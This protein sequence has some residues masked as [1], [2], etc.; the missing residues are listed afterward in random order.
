MRNPFRFGNALSAAFS[1]KQPLFLLAAFCA[2]LLFSEELPLDRKAFAPAAAKGQKIT[3]VTYAEK[4]ALHFEW[5]CDQCPWAEFWWDNRPLLPDFGQLRIRVTAK[6]G[7]AARPGM[8]SLRFIDRDGEAFQ[9]GNPLRFDEKGI[10]ETEFLIP[11]NYKIHSAWKSNTESVLNGKIDQPLRFGGFCFQYPG[12]SGK[13]EVD[14]TKVE[15]DSRNDEIGAVAGTSV[16]FPVQFDIETGHPVRVVTPETASSSVLVLRNTGDAELVP[17][18][19]FTVYDR[20]GGIVGRSWTER[21]LIGKN[22]SR[23]LLLPRMEKFGIYYVEAEITCKN[24]PVQKIVRSFAYLEPTGHAEPYCKG[25]FRFGVNTDFCHD[26]VTWHKEGEACRTI[27]MRFIRNG[28]TLSHFPET[29]KFPEYATA[30]IDTFL[31][32]GVMTEYLLFGGGQP[33]ALQQPE[34]AARDRPNTFMPNLEAWRRYCRETFS[35]LKTRV[36]AFEVWNEPDLRSFA[37]FSPEEYVQLARIARE[38]QRKIAPDAE[39]LSAGFCVAEQD[40]FQEKAMRLC[41]ELFDVHCFHG[42]GPFESY[43]TIITR[44]FLPMRERLGIAGVMPWYAHETAISSS[45][46]GE[47]LQAETYF[48]KLLFSWRHGAIG[49]TWYNLHNN[50]T[51]PNN[52]EHNYG[53]LTYD[54]YP[55]AVFVAGNTLT[56]L[57]G[58][59]TRYEADLSEIPYFTAYR[60]HREKQEFLFPAWH[61][62]RGGRAELR[63]RTDAKNA[64]NVDLQGNRTPLQIQDGVVIFPVSGE[65]STLRLTG[66]TRCDKLGDSVKSAEREMRFGETGGTAVLTVINP[67][68]NPVNLTIEQEPMEGIAMRPLAPQRFLP[69]EERR[70]ELQFH[71]DAAKPIAGHPVRLRY[72]LGAETGLVE[73]P[74]LPVWKLSPDFTGVP[75]AVLDKRSQMVELFDADPANVFR[76]R[77][78]NSDL[79]CRLELAGDENSFRLRAEVIDD[80]HRQPNRGAAIFKGDSIQLFLA[81]PGQKQVWQLGCAL[82]DQ[83]KVEPYIWEAGAPGGKTGPGNFPCR[84][85]RAGTKTVYEVTLPWNELGVSAQEAKQGFRFNFLVNESDSDVR[86]SFLRLAPGAGE[87]LEPDQFPLLRL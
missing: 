43:R 75:F 7:T 3:N 53:M 16:S 71:G 72:S 74:V 24:H 65:P 58:G 2:V 30:Y 26:P 48:K 33:W 12:Q 29:M 10:A 4:P 82:T 61:E 47:K 55:K 50:G 64:E 69:G 15:I 57:F 80:L 5:D 34:W 62:Q 44:Q 37:K 14:I 18:V 39:L 76:L 8:L 9:A 27:G 66:A 86:E 40:Q 51:D 49:Y 63:F 19:R 85:D 36:G 23:A 42:H 56:G 54:Y 38:E 84:V 46:W 32:Y 21:P 25:R 52:S 87:R 79:S 78:D 13:G 17:A 67:E 41:R 6:A 1:L 60:F 20:D 83:G 11:G 70:V 45:G 22:A 68:K 81:F 31:H 77:R 59:D 35:R 73:L 28:F